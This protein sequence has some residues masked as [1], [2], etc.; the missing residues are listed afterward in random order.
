MLKRYQPFYE[1]T[2][3]KMLECS[4]QCSCNESELEEADQAHCDA[5]TQKKA[6]DPSKPKFKFA[7]GACEVGGC[8]SGYIPN[9]DKTAC[10]QMPKK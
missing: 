7:G 5:R 8:A 4:T 6:S 10:I 3:K 9:K 2:R 1:S